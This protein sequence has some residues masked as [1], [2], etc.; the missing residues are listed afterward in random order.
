MNGGNG[1]GMEILSARVDGEKT[2]GFKVMDRRERGNVIEK[3]HDEFMTRL[4]LYIRGRFH[5]F[6]NPY[7]VLSRGSTKPDTVD[8][9]KLPRSTSHAL[10]QK[11]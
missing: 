1:R 6:R 2:S 9:F 10:Y 4:S 3:R 7:A 8:R 5:A 11:R